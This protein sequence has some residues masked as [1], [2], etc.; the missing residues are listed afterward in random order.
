MD[1]E[2]AHAGMSRRT[3]CIGAGGT[4]VL[5]AL[6]GLKALPVQASVRPPGG[7]DDAHVIGACIR[8]ERCVEACPKG[9]LHP[10]HVEDGILAVRTPAANFN[11]GWCDFCTESH[12]G[13]PQ[14]VAYCP[15]G[16][17]TLPEGA[18]AQSVILGKASITKDWCLAWNRNNG[19]RFCYDACPY[20]AIV[21]DDHKRPVVVPDACNGCGA[22][23]NACVS[24]QEGSIA[25]GATERAIIVRPIAE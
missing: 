5:F 20:E 12:G 10:S 6:G 21:L 11:E 24:L 15:T 1:D 3:L 7:Q 14:C 22:C 9:A 8:C 17:L 23:Q 19:C 25:E 13:R 16:A 2:K 18:T 4:V